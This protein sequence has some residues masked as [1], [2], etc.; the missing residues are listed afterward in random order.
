[1]RDSWSRRD[2]VV[3]SSGWQVPATVAT[4]WRMAAPRRASA[5]RAPRPAAWVWGL[6]GY[7]CEAAPPPARRSRRPRVLE[8]HRRASADANAA[9]GD[10]L[11]EAGREVRDRS[12]RGGVCDQLR[13]RLVGVDRRGVHDRR[14]RGHVRERSLAQMKRR[15][16]VGPEGALPLV[17]G[18][19]LE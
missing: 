13:R 17:V 15:A 4:A 8:I 18:N 19:V 12:L 10:G 16:D 1:I 14:A 2:R 9:L 6:A 7:R 11:A 5:D 3:A